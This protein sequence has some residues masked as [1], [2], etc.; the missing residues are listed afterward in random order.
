[1]VFINGFYKFVCQPLPIF[2]TL[3][4]AFLA[5]QVP[6]SYSVNQSHLGVFA[7]KQVPLA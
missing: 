3:Q 1:M 5:C 4:L 7:I 2:A 6:F